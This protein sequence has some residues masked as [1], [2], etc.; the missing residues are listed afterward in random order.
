MSRIG[1]MPVVI[2]DKVEVTLK[3]NNIKVK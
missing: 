2:S 1:K 3:D